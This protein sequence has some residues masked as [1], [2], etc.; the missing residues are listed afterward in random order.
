MIFLKQDFLLGRGDGNIES[1]IFLVQLAQSLLEIKRTGN[2]VK[3]INFCCRKLSQLWEKKTPICCHTGKSLVQRTVAKD[4]NTEYWLFSGQMIK[5]FSIIVFLSRSPLNTM[6]RVCRDIKMF[7]HNGSCLKT[8][9]LESKFRTSLIPMN[10]LLV[11]LLFHEC[12]SIFPC[13]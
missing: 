5:T 3:T 9:H 6:E 11:F 1:C 12:S 4:E 10:C 2:L 13:L 7:Q 8:K